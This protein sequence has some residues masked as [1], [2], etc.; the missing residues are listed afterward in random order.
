MLV[1]SSLHQWMKKPPTTSIWNTFIKNKDIPACKV[2]LEATKCI[3]VSSLFYVIPVFFL[4]FTKQDWSLIKRRWFL[5]IGICSYVEKNSLLFVKCINYIVRTKIVFLRNPKFTSSITRGSYRCET[6][7]CGGVVLNSTY[8]NKPTL[9]TSIK[10]VKKN[11]K[12]TPQKQIHD[13]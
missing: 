13:I 4:L 3:N 8:S 7:Q 10:N 12:K 1:Y 2:I 11:N 9:K 5:F 6:T